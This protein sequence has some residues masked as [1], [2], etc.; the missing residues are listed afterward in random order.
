MYRNK[1][2]MVLG[3]TG[4][5]G[6]NLSAALISAGVRPCLVGRMRSRLRL[7]VEPGT[8]HFEEVSDLTQPDLVEDLIL[9]HQ[10]QVVFNLVACDVESSEK[11]PEKAH[12]TNC[13][14]VERAVTAVSGINPGTWQGARFVHTGTAL[15][16]GAVHGPLH[17]DGPAVPTTVYGRTKLEGTLT[18]KKLAASNDIPAITARLFTV[19]GPFEAAGRLLPYLAGCAASGRPARL[20]QGIQKR[21]FTFVADVVEGLLRLGACSR[22]RG[23]PVNLATGKLT[24]VSEFVQAAALVLGMRPEKLRFGQLGTRPWEMKHK[25]VTIRRLLDLTGWAPLTM[26]PAGIEETLEYLN[27]IMLQNGEV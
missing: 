17:E 26:P 24:S 13:R 22:P 8:F 15:E 20:T 5:I 23:T 21:D 16:Y 6:T 25:P 7:S 11:K 10:P 2:V 27:S 9:T 4:F 18:L 1:R 12:E 14:L 3:S 19:Y